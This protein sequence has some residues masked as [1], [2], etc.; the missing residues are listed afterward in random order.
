MPTLD[1]QLWCRG[2]RAR[3]GDAVIV[4]FQHH[5]T[6]VRRTYYYEYYRSFDGAHGNTHAGAG[7][8]FFPFTFHGV[9]TVITLT[10][11]QQDDGINVQADEHRDINVVRCGWIGFDTQ[12]SRLAS[13][14]ANHGGG[15]FSPAFPSVVKTMYVHRL[16][17]SEMRNI[18]TR[19]VV[20][21]C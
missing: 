9:G 18:N 20:A 14:V 1:E 13:L 12:S 2:H 6:A 16:M 21:F 5:R 11:I 3:G 15:T 4:V 10:T 19:R 8:K 17:T 7:S